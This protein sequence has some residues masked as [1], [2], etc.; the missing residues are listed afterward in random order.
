VLVKVDIHAGY[1]EM[2]NSGHYPPLFFSDRILALDSGVVLGVKKDEK[3]Q[4]V[5]GIITK[6][7][8][9]ILHGWCC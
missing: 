8:G 6:G 1:F 5:K 2:A 3:Y 7:D 4:L 9:M